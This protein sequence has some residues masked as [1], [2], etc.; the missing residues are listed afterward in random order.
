[1]WSRP[2]VLGSVSTSLLVLVQCQYSF[3]SSTCKCH[4]RSPFI[5]LPFRRLVEEVLIP[6]HDDASLSNKQGELAGND[7]PCSYIWSVTTEDAA[8][9]TSSPSGRAC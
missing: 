9:R 3:L 2:K 7:Q 5:Q 1:M 6:E 8:P 4:S